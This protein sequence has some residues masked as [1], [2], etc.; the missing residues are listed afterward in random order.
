[1]VSIIIPCYNLQNYIGDTLYSVICQTDSDWEIIAVDDG[2]S[3]DTYEVLT[4]FAQKDKRIHIYHQEN[5]GVSSARNNGLRLAKGDWIYFLD[6]DDIIVNDLVQKI[7]NT[8]H[9]KDIVI[10]DFVREKKGNVVK[11]YRVTNPKTLFINY[12]TN[13][14]TIHISSIAIKRSFIASNN[15]FFDENTGYGE[16]RE[17]IAAV[18]SL[19]PLYQC[20]DKIAFRYQY[21][22]DSAVNSHSYNN[23]RFSSILASERTYNL[24][25]G[26]PEEKKALANLSFT[27]TRHIKMYYEYGCNDSELGRLLRLYTDKYLKG[28]HY[29]GLGHVELYASLAGV[30]AYNH[31]ILRLFLKL[32]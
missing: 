7:N 32:A 23:R 26:R 18:F 30:L 9:N 13:K 4:K 6:G 1:M 21:R 17:F 12:L 28:F 25:Q 8:D 16:D 24:L 19:N 20:I 2:S 3:D 14:Q 11:T 29:Y 22:A 27:I 31:N 5:K 15:I 10:F